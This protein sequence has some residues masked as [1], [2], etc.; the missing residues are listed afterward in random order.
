MSKYEDFS[1]SKYVGTSRDVVV[2]A[3]TKCISSGYFENLNIETVLLPEGLEEIS[4]CAF[5]GCVNLKSINFPKSLKKIGSEAFKNCKKLDISNFDACLTKIYHSAFY[6]CKSLQKMV[7][8]IDAQIGDYAFYNCFLNELVLKHQE[9]GLEFVNENLEKFRSA[10]FHCKGKSLIL[11]ENVN[12]FIGAL[13]EY[14]DDEKNPDICPIFNFSEIYL[15]KTIQEIDS[16]DV[17]HQFD[18]IVFYGNG[19]LNRNVIESLIQ[20]K[21]RDYMVDE[22][23]I[24][25]NRKGTFPDCDS[26]VPVTIINLSDKEKEIIQEGANKIRIIDYR[27]E[28]GLC[29]KCGNKL[30]RKSIINSY[31]KCRKCG[32]EP[33]N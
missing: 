13:Y 26:I 31:K 20:R 14:Y 11:D 32:Y 22:D 33:E 29:I 21:G 7:I 2:P 15:P 3:G 24:I 16:K 12:S 18:K 28:N 4:S 27:K 10:F 19:Q 25:G 6:G 8:D 17:L 5:K 30:T 9:H 23:R 1:F